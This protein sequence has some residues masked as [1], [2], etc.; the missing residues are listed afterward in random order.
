MAA[1]YL[2]KMG[3][4]KVAVIVPDLATENI[5]CRLQGFLTEF[6][7]ALQIKTKLS[8]SGGQ[9]VVAELLEQNIEAVFALS[10]ELAF[11]IYLGMRQNGK[12]IPNDLS[13]IGYDDV[14][15][16]RY[17]TPAL[18]T[19]AQPIYELGKQAADLMIKR[20]ATPTSPYVKRV[21][22]VKLV[23]RGSVKV[24]I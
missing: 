20:L 14:E 16:C 8:K 13:V 5:S 4:T 21:L 3:H 9:A 22:P 19:V 23:I 1:Q 6:P 12:S 11:G 10:D 2:K 24:K 18:T 7:Q 17:V 15:M